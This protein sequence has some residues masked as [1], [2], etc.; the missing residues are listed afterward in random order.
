MDEVIKQA[1]SNISDDEIKE[2]FLKN[3]SNIT[4]TLA[5]LW[6]LEK[7]KEKELNDW[8]KRRKLLDE[9][10]EECYKFINKKK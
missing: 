7:P 4:N 1:P 5:E 6:L 3:D 10:E 2:I 8:D 9:M